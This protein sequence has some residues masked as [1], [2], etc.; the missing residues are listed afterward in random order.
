MTDGIPHLCSTGKSYS[1]VN[2]YHCALQM[3]SIHFEFTFVLLRYLLG[4]I[5]PKQTTHQR[6]SWASIPS[7]EK[8]NPKRMVFHLKFQ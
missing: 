6:F 4:A 5:R 7:S 2:I 3:V 8:K 1:Q